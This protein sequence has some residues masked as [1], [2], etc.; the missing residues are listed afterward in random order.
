MTENE[1]PKTFTCKEF[2]DMIKDCQQNF[3]HKEMS[4]A[5][6]SMTGLLMKKIGVVKEAEDWDGF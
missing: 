2:Y 6:D 3:Y 5:Q 1:M 4:A